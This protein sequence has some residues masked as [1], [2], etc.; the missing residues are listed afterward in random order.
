MRP[1]HRGHAVFLRSLPHVVSV[2]DRGTVS[3]RPAAAAHRA[4]RDAAALFSAA[5]AC[6][7]LSA[8]AARRTS[9][10][11]FLAALQQL[12]LAVWNA[13]LPL[14]ARLCRLF[15]AGPLSQPQGAFA[16]S[17]PL[18]LCA[19]R[20]RSHRHRRYDVLCFPP[21][22]HRH[23]ALLQ[24]RLGLCAADVSRRLCIRP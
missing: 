21:S 1:V 11:V 6:F 15:Y 3:D 17:G 12:P 24:L 16:Q 22:G 4:E 2:Y 7:Q 9:F 10:S 5:C 19:R 13:I 23:R 8:A 20:S 14:H 18:V